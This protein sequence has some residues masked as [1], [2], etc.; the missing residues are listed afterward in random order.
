VLAEVKTAGPRSIRALGKVDKHGNVQISTS[1]FQ[2]FLDLWRRTG[3]DVDAIDTAQVSADNA[4]HFYV[5]A[6]GAHA[7]VSQDDGS[8]TF[9]AGNPTR[10]L[11]AVW[12]TKAGVEAARRTLR[13][14]LTTAAGTTAVT[15]VSNTGLATAFV[16]IDD[17]TNSVRADVTV[18]FL[19]GSTDTGSL[20]W[21][22]SD[23][24]A[25]LSTPSSGGG[26]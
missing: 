10:D 11:A 22:A 9:T 25:A 6:P 26:K 20:S 2:F 3:S 8:G 19:D 16:L 17:G 15:N 7:W 18:T 14:T 24:S 21:T 5:P 13:G 1:A 23:I 12:F 4:A